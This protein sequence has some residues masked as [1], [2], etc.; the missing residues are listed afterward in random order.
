MLNKH[1][2]C[3]DVV[4]NLACIPDLCKTNFCRT[5]LC[6][7][8]F[9]CKIIRVIYYPL[10]IDEKLYPNCLHKSGAGKSLVL[11]RVQEHEFISSPIIC[12]NDPLYYRIT[13]A[14]ERS[15]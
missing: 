7:S 12:T 5:I 13:R 10:L 9:V 2:L 4:P 1:S 3:G 8:F 11:V 14:K 15:N 6:T